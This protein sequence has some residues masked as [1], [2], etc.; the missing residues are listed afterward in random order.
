MLEPLS[1]STLHKYDQ[2]S[3]AI[4]FD[5]AIRSIFLDLE[6]RPRLTKERKLVIE[7]KFR[8]D[9]LGDDLIDVEC[10]SKVKVVIPEKESRVNILAPSRKSGTLMFNP[11]TPRARQHML[12]FGPDDE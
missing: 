10:S 2:G 4:L 12:E 11:E 1:L 6:D 9:D 8:P 5:R 3:L 7:L